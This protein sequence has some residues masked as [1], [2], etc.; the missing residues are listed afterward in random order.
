MLKGVGLTYLW[1]ETLILA[2]MGAVLL[3]LSTRS[4]RV[5]LE[6]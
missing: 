4:F 2:G 5:R 6:A 3:V 1:R